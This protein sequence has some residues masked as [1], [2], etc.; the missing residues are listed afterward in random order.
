MTVGRF[1]DDPQAVNA[2]TY[3]EDGVYTAAG[4]T[5]EVENVLA[6]W[7]SSENLL[8]GSWAA[9][10][11][12][13]TIIQTAEDTVNFTSNGSLRGGLNA[14]FV[15]GD[16]F[17]V[18]VDVKNVD[19]SA[20]I[21]IAVVDNFGTSNGCEQVIVP[22][23]TWKRYAVTLDTSSIFGSTLT[24]V[25]LGVADY[26]SGNTIQCR[27]WQVEDVTARANQN[28]ST[29]LPKGVSKALN[30]YFHQE[31]LT[32]T[33]TIAAN[34]DAN[35]T[36]DGWLWGNSAWEITGNKANSQSIGQSWHCKQD[37]VIDRF[38]DYHYS[39]DA[40]GFL[41]GGVTFCGSA[42]DGSAGADKTDRIQATTV[43]ELV[44]GTNNTGLIVDHIAV[45]ECDA[46]TGVDGVA[47]RAAYGDLTVDPITFVVTE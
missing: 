2:V 31:D 46:T 32:G 11:A 40:V 4:A 33:G 30:S 6:K 1:H 7:T 19:V 39:I 43:S 34:G 8:A 10:A 20:T 27:R 3:D 23:G 13:T 24:D 16:I 37:S 17:T 21:K 12:G 41:G 42:A 18:S 26:V 28:P 44:T 9:I 36:N 25:A 5:V 22:D 29:Y 14:G 45:V 15:K 38:Y 35:T 47:N